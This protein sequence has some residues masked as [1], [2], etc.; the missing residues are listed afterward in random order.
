MVIDIGGF[1]AD[2]LAIRNGQADLAVC[3]TLEHGVIV[4]EAVESLG[5]DG[6]NA[7]IGALDMFRKK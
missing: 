3:D 6:F 7:I 2:Y 5:E 1:S 4:D